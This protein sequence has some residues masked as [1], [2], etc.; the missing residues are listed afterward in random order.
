MQRLRFLEPTAAFRARYQYQ[1]L[2]F[3]AAGYLTEQVTGKSWDDQVRERIF[4][5][6]GMVRS[7]TSVR[8]SPGAGDF[9]HPY[10]WRDGK[11]VRL[12]FRNLDPVGPAGSIN[13]TIDDMLKYIQFRID[14]GEAGGKRLLSLDNE[15]QMQAPQMHLSTIPDFRELGHSAYGLGLN[16]T[17]YRGR[18]Q[19]GHG[20]GIDG[21]I[22]A[23]AWL[24]EDRIGV[25]VMTNL[26]GNNP[27]PTLVQ[28]QVFDRLLGITPIDWVSRQ[29]RLDREAQGRAQ[30]ARETRAKERKPGTAPSHPLAAYAGRFEHPGYGAATIAVVGSALQVSIDDV[31]AP[32]GH[33]HYDV[34]ELADPGAVVPFSG[35]AE[36][37]SGPD[38]TI[39][40]VRLPLE[41]ALPGIEFRRVP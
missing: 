23:M 34:F 10:T 12:P 14:M 28:R 6:L 38:G 7:N 13:S 31:V 27:V 33:Y 25:M 16:V 3:M 35:L 17:S 20:G 8:E 15:R 18:R 29:R 22:S 19:V 41:A 5:P 24:P 21:F 2:M 9:S 30:T 36:F 40:R 11:W 37:L 4:A 39:D 32:L 1:N 26:S